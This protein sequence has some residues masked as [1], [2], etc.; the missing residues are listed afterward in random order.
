MILRTCPLRLITSFAHRSTFGTDC[1]GEQ[2]KYVWLPQYQE[3]KILLE[4]YL[5][6]ITYI[7]HVIHSPSARGYLDELYEGL[8]Q[9][10]AIK[11][12]LTAL[13]LSIFASTT[14]AWTPRDNESLFSSVEEANN[15]TTL[16]ITTALAVLEFS[17]STTSG[18]I[19]DIQA[20]IILSFAVCNVEGFSSRFWTL[21]ST[22]ISMA[23]Q[24]SLHRIDHVS[25]VPVENMTDLSSTRV[26]IYRRVWWYLMATDW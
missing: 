19:E 4:K 1:I 2:S 13:F 11:P 21:K 26:E 16:W 15:Q 8:E 6:D 24:L 7:H 22:A 3:A 5:Q 18:S 14:F 23:R 10:A 9:Q 17:H 12:G 20:M 25:S